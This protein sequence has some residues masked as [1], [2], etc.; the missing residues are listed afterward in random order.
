MWILD[1]DRSS[2]RVAD[3]RYVLLSTNSVNGTSFQSAD[4]KT[5]VPTTEPALHI[6][7]GEGPHVVN[8]HGKKWLNWEGPG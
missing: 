5:W 4:L 7:V 6:R 2:L 1:C 8:F 3:G